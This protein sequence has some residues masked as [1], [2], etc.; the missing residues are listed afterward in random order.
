MIPTILI[1]IA[2]ASS[3]GAIVALVYGLLKGDVWLTRHVTINR[4]T[5]YMYIAL[6]TINTIF[7]ATMTWILYEASIS[8]NPF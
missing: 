5:A 8:V 4:W 2:L 6:L 3:I 7:T 1:T